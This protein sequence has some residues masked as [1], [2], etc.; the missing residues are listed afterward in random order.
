MDFVV[1]GEEDMAVAAMVVVGMAMEGVMVGVDMVAADM[2]VVAAAV[3]VEE[4]TATAVVDTEAS[5]GEDHIIQGS[6]SYFFI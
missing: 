2:V 4:A 3:M 1:T 6:Y 5:L